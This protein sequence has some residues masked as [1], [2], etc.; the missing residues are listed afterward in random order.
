M[1]PKAATGTAK[2]IDMRLHRTASASAC[3]RGW[4]ADGSL[5]MGRRGPG[6]SA[7]GAE[8]ID[9]RLAKQEARRIVRS[10]LEA[11]PVVMA[12]DVRARR[13]WSD[14]TR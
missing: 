5:P 2:I 14:A 1:I 8:D 11:A 6:V 9:R 7:T 4:N 12:Q 3:S 10:A 13:I